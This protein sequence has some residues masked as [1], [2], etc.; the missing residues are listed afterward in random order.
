VHGDAPDVDQLTAL[1]ADKV[2][3]ERVV[4]ADLGPVV[5]THAGPRTIGVAYQVG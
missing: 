1:L 4:I 5:G 3:P 2:P